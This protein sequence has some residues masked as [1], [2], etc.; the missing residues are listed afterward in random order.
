MLV[1]TSVREVQDRT[2]EQRRGS[3]GGDRGQTRHHERE[4]PVCGD[5]QVQRRMSQ[6]LD[7][8]FERR[9]LERQRQRIVFALV[10]W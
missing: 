2:G 4:R 9:R 5:P 8:L 1:R 3:V 6:Q 10:R 7:A